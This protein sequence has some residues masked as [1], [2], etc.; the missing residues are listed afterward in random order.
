MLMFRLELILKTLKNTARKK[1]PQATS[2]YRFCD[3]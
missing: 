2:K 1:S 3:T